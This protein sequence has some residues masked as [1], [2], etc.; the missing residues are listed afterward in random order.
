[1]RDF[2]LSL[3]C[4]AIEIGGLNILGA[5]MIVGVLP[6]LFI[7]GTSCLTLIFFTSFSA[8]AFQSTMSILRHQ[9]RQP[10]ENPFPY[11]DIFAILLVST[12]FTVILATNYPIVNVLTAVEIPASLV[13]MMVV[14]IR[15]HVDDPREPRTPPS[16]RIP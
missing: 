1:M 9:A 5:L 6:C 3:R 16:D 8:L 12:V 7:L 2:V 11:M 15:S 4:S 13:I 10:D 14:I